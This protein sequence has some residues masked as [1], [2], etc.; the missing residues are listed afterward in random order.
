MKLLSSHRPVVGLVGGLCLGLADY[1]ILALLGVEMTIGEWDVTLWVMGLY[2]FTFA[3]LGWVIGR[4]LDRGDETEEQARVIREQ[5]E[6]LEETHRE[7]VESRQL[8]AIGRMAAGVAHEVRNPLGVI[9]TSARMVA[10][11]LEE[12]SEAR[13]AADFI[14]E[15]VDRLDVFVAK[16]LDFSKPL[17]ADRRPVDVAEVIDRALASVGGRTEDKELT[18]EVQVSDGADTEFPGDPD[19]LYQLFAGLLDNAVEAV[20]SG[21]HI[22]LTIANDGEDVI[23]EVADDG[24]GIS[25]DARGRL[26]EPFFTTRTDGTG[27]GLVMARKIADVHGGSLDYVAGAGLGD[28]SAGARFRLRLPGDSE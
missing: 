27:L 11:D 5:Y 12:G 13:R 3:A 14:S 16:L 22:Q 23:V 19:L 8:A 4:L 21:G 2:A 6:E 15:E 25:P 17:D 7:L 28:D 9:R 26:F 24:P 18:T 10:E 20:E 1:G